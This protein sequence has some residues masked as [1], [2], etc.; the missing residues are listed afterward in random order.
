MRS[1]HTDWHK[2]LNSAVLSDVAG[3]TPATK[4]ETSI[5]KIPADIKVADENFKLP[6]DIDLYLG[7][8]LF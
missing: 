3:T 8:D 1:R 5:W 2:S 7:A 6:G 4:L